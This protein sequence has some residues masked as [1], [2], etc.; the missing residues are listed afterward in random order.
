[1][2]PGEKEITKML[3][4]TGKSHFKTESVMIKDMTPSTGSLI[5]RWKRSKDA[6]MATPNPARPLICGNSLT[7]CLHLE[8]S[9]FTLK[10]CSSCD[11]RERESLST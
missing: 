7:G 11:L 9:C 3:S 6:H 1:M 8:T 10:N 5:A 2:Q 4:V